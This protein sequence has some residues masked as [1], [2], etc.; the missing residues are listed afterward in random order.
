[1][2]HIAGPDRPAPDGS[3]GG[4]SQLA[5]D[6]HSWAGERISGVRGRRSRH[7]A[8]TRSRVRRH[9][10]S[11]RLLELDRLAD[12]HRSKMRGSGLNEEGVFGPTPDPLD[13]ISVTG[14]S[15]AGRSRTGRRSCTCQHP[16]PGQPTT[17]SV[18]SIACSAWPPSSDT[19]SG[20]N[21]REPTACRPDAGNVDGRCRQ[22]SRPTVIRSGSDRPSPAPRLP[23]DR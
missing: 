23:Q 22:V 11:W 10:G 8:L 6:H 16:H 9:Y 3:P 2:W 19:G 20:T 5:R 21:A 12:P 15:A 18:V 13:Q 7:T 1:M 17:L 4:P 14:R